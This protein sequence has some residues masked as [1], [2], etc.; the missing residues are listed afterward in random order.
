MVP[1]S[2]IL[3]SESSDLFRRTFVRPERP[4]HPQRLAYRRTWVAGL[5]IHFHLFHIIVSAGVQSDANLKAN[6]T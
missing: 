2:H 5:K 1:V 3:P 6:K 4:L